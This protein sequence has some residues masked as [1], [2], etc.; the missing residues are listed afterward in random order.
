MSESIKAKAEEAAAGEFT[1]VKAE[2]L[3]NV[4]GGLQ[5]QPLPPRNIVVRSA[6]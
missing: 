6:Q 3:E 2:E 1:E 5:P 4:E